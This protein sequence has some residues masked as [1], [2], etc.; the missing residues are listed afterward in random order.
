MSKGLTKDEWISRARIVHGDKY[1]YSKTEYVNWKT[2]V[3]IICPIHG[4]FWQIANSHLQGFGCKK[5]SNLLKSE[6]MTFGK[7]EFINKA[8]KKHGN[9][10]DYSKVI[11]ES[12]WK[13]VCIICPIHGEFWQTPRSHLYGRGCPICGDS[14]LEKNVAKILTIGGISYE[15]Q[16]TFDW[17]GKKSL[18][19]YLPE[20]N[21]AIECQGEQHYKPVEHFGGEETFNDIIKRDICKNKLC[22]EHNISLLY[23]SEK[24]DKFLDELTV[25]KNNLLNIIEN[26]NNNKCR[27]A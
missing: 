19:F 8:K 20:Y 9:K 11:Y 3:C 2:K 5:C 1:D 4:E 26:G 10:Y 27:R 14:I 13:R 25:N 18:D 15:R 24:R 6:K 22:K 12:Y 17:L 23:Y 7:D 21:M 16:K